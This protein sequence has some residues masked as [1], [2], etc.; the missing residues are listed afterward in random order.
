VLDA[1][2]LLAYLGNETGADVVADAIAA[3]ATISTVDL[4]EAL[5]TLAD[6]GRDP[7]TVATELTQRGLLDGA[8]TIEPFIAAD[9]IEAAR[10][11]P[12]TRSAGLSLANRACLAL[13][14]RLAVRLLT[15]DQAWSGLDVGVEVEVIR[16]TTEHGEDDS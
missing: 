7:A 4:A 9:S 8:I 16:A 14:R 10:L 3:G 11:R 2:A 6:R 13:A 1:S 5:S 15:A 12:L